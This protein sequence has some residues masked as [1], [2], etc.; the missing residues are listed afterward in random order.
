MEI[1][2]VV[3]SRCKGSGILPEFKHVVNGKCFCCNGTGYITEESGIKEFHIH[4]YME[5]Y[6]KVMPWIC[7]DAETEKEAFKKAKTI[8][9]RGCY[10]DYID[11]IVITGW[12]QK[13]NYK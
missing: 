1:K 12:E 2:K 5:D 9:K 13:S 4:I 8:C 6:K 10:K 7:V 11:T 3:C